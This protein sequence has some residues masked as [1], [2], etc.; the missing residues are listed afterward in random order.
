[1]FLMYENFL[2]KNQCDNVIDVYQKNENKSFQYRDTFPLILTELDWQENQLLVNIT[3]SVVNLC[4][5][6]TE[7]QFSLDGAQIVRWPKGSFQDEH[8]DTGDFLASIIYLNDNYLG[9]KTCFMIDDVVKITPQIGKC[10]IFSNS[11]YLHWVEKV[12]K[13]TRYTLAYWFV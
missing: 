4:K 9:G 2:T 8:Y 1:M 11:K 12:Q 7:K 5:K 13:N 10:I 3:N 6:I